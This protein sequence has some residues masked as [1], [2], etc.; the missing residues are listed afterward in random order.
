MP[1]VA[2]HETCEDCQSKGMVDGER[3]ATCG[4]RGWVSQTPEM[5]EVDATPEEAPKPTY[6]EAR[7]AGYTPEAAA[8]LA[9]LPAPPDPDPTTTTSPA[10][11]PTG[12]TDPPASST[13]SQADGSTTESSPTTSPSSR[14]GGDEEPPAAAPTARPATK[15]AARARATRAQA[16]AKA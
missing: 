1:M 13:P 6:Q 7:D 2:K 11:S 12:E 14:P 15:R 16:K 3:C 9:G 4:G 10:T 5:P 8:Q